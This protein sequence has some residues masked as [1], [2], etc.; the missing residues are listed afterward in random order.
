MACLENST[1]DYCWFLG[2]D[3][4]INSDGIKVV[5]SALEKFNPDVLLFDRENFDKEMLASRGIH[6]F[7][8]ENEETLVNSAEI[9]ELSS[10]LGAINDLGGVFSYL[11]SIIVK[12]ESWDQTI[13]LSSHIGSAYLHTSRIFQ[14][15][16][17]GSSLVYIP[18]PIVKNRMG[19][20]FFAE[21]GYVNR[22][23]IDLNYF[24]LINDIF[25]GEKRKV[26]LKNVNRIV[27]SYK[28]LLAYKFWAYQYEGSRGVK[29]LIEGYERINIDW[30]LFNVKKILL[31]LFPVPVLSFVYHKIYLKFLKKKI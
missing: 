19:N 9:S 26:F 25:E 21:N 12:R 30:G 3:D 23:L 13:V 27:A 28:K 16:N 14:M 1:G 22:V 4:H 20:D 10:Y 11:S 31:S 5:L 6:K 29:A 18:F 2:S 24:T 8:N 15:L 17:Q 7:L